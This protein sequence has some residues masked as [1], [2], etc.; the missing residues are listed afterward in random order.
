MAN[1]NLQRME[2]LSVE[3]LVFGGE[4]AGGVLV[5]EGV[6]R[7][8]KGMLQPQGLGETAVDVGSKG[9]I[10]VVLRMLSGFT[11]GITSDALGVASWG[12]FAWAMLSLIFAL[13]PQLGLALQKAETI[14]SGGDGIQRDREEEPVMEA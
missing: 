12:A 14:R 8:F 13:V 9:V 1:V 4:I 3:G 6:A 7:F 11:G 5:A 10:G 2:M